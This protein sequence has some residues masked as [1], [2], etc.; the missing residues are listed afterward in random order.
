[1]WVFG[2]GSLIWNAGFD[3]DERRVGF[4]KGYRRL[5]HQGSTDH[6]GTPANPGRTVTLEPHS[7]HICWGVAYR[8]SGHQAEQIAL[9]Y[10]EVREKQY[11]RKI[12]TDFFTDENST[13]PTISDVLVYIASTDKKLNKNYLGPAPLETIARQ[14]VGARGPSGPNLEYLLKLEAAL[15]EMGCKDDHVIDLANAA[16]KALTWKDENAS[17]KEE[18]A[19]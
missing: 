5:F 19:K 1:M 14:I 17:L 18:D 12:Y 4:I 11:D 9:S 10:L 2:Y 15:T 13:E 7:G 16:R 8:V 6:R 3:Y